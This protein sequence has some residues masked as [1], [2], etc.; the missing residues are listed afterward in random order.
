MRVGYPS[1]SSGS[2]RLIGRLVGSLGYEVRSKR[3]P[4]LGVEEE[5]LDLYAGCRDYTMTS[6]ERMY[7][8]YA[9]VKYLARNETPGDMVECGV[10][11]GGSTMMTLRTLLSC[12]DSTREVYL[13]DTFEGMP[14]PSERDV[15]LYDGR[16]AQQKWDQH[17]RDG[18]N[19]WGYASLEEVDRNLRRT[20]YPMERL[21][22]VKGMVE[23]TIPATIPGGIALLR[24]D[25]DFYDST[26]HEFVHLYPLV[27]SGGVVIIDDYGDWQGSREATDRYLTEQG[28][29]PLLNRIDHTGRL[30]IKS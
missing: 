16:S 30:I 2:R 22:L 29:Q 3:A 11:R 8:V 5:F 18:Y 27:A 25:T 19:A 9:A 26:Y 6:V 4:L 7:A 14:S 17:Q 20:G 23:Q 21:H 28:L 10:W 1:G 12:G 13:Y 15:S 24:L